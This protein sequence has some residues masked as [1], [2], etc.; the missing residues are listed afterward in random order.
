MIPGRA[1]IPS[2]CQWL[3]AFRDANGSGFVPEE[4]PCPTT[5]VPSQDTGLLP[6][7]AR[8]RGMYWEKT[9]EA[10]ARWETVEGCGDSSLVGHARD[11]EAL[12]DRGPAQ[13]QSHELLAGVSLV[14]SNKD[15]TIDL[16]YYNRH[17]PPGHHNLMRLGFAGIR[18]RARERLRTETDAGKR[19]FLQA[20][21]ISHDAACRFADKHGLHLRELA[22]AASQTRSAELVQIARVCEELARGAPESFH[23]GLQLLWFVFVLGGSGCIGRFDQWLWPLLEQDLRSG[24]LTRPAAAELL[25]SLWIKL[26]FFAGNNDTL[27]NVSLAGQ[28]PEGQDGCNELT[29]LCLEATEALRLPE[30]KLN[31]RFFEGSPPEL[32]PACCRLL[33]GGLSQPSIYNDPIAI[34]GLTRAGVPIEDARRYCNDGCEEIILGGM[35]ASQFMTYDTLAVLNESVF[36]AEKEPYGSFGELFRDFKQRL[37]RWMPEGCGEPQG[38]TFPFFAATIDDC[39][40]SGSPLGARYHI[41]GNIIAETANSADGLTAIKR[42]VFERQEFSWPELIAALRADYEGHEPLR[43]MLLNQAP[44]FGNDDDEVDEIATEIAHFFLEG[45]HERAG[46]TPGTGLKRLAGLMSFGLQRKQQLPATPDGRRQGDNTANSYSPTPGR[47]RRGPTAVLNS[48]GKLDATKATFGATLDL[49]LHTSTLAGPDG[50]DKLRAL[51]ATFLGKPCTTTLQLNVI[52]RETLLK[53]QADSAN[54]EYRTLI[55]RVWGFSAVFPELIP[56]LQA[57]V[58]ER[59]Q[60]GL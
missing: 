29:F 15:S 23:A 53:A 24:R 51:L 58:L 9:H 47:D 21:A 60:H 7:I 39:L 56:E 41:T 4:S 6:R 57:H 25:Q 19:D 20:V 1:T 30:P 59:T 34:A 36:R 31:V 55:V 49:A 33:A 48:V 38:I 40:A 13:I 42:L 43:Q 27:R 52:D 8:L 22:E 26:N 32:L 11:F 35:C 54:P 28:T 10:L 44:K 37:T 16:G 3:L 5:V 50:L 14:R 17:Y 46:N 18:D 45:V 2:Q 12:L